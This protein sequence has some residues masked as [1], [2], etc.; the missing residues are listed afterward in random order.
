M[1]KKKNTTNA[2]DPTVEHTTR[3]LR[4]R[5]TPEEAHGKATALVHVLNERNVVEAE[6][7]DIKAQFRDRLRRIADREK[8]L[9]RDVEDSSED[10]SVRC[11]VERD[12]ERGMVLTRRVDTGEIV[13]ERPLEESE[14]Q[15]EL[16]APTEVAA[17]PAEGVRA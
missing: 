14:R 1:A 6:L 4:V 5:L 15:L 17:E 16:G 2:L 3:R 8:Q 12:Y 9:R 11:S 13:E 10:R 7:G